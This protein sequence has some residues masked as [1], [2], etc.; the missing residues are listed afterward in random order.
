MLLGRGRLPVRQI[1][2][3]VFTVLRRCRVL[4][5]RR[6]EQDCLCNELQSSRTCGGRAGTDVVS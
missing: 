4:K 2:A 1:C 5:A 6:C 3:L